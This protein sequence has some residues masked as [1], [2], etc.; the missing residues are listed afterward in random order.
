MS[1]EELR[2]SI[3]RDPRGLMIHRPLRAV[4]IAQ[5]FILL[6]AAVMAWFGTLPAPPVDHLSLA[7]Q[8]G[9]VR[10]VWAFLW[11]EVIVVFV[12]S[13]LGA[14][15]LHK[16]QFIPWC[17]LV[18]LLPGSCAAVSLVPTCSE[19]VPDGIIYPLPEGSTVVDDYH[20]TWIGG[21]QYRMVTVR[22]PGLAAS[23]FRDE[24]MLLFEARGWETSPEPRNQTEWRGRLDRSMAITVGSKPPNDVDVKISVTLYERDLCVD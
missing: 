6:I 1:D 3:E 7:E 17:F 16:A 15:L 24:L 4:L 14:S 10:F 8:I 19:S 20:S 21:T 13:T 11:L 22:Q 9:P 5:P 12:V 2:S 18:I 23:A